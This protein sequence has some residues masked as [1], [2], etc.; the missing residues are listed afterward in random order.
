MIFQ[1]DKSYFPIEFGV[2]TRGSP[3]NGD[4]LLLD[5]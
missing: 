2:K 4:F 5:I 1:V 3:L